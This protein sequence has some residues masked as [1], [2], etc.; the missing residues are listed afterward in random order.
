MIT[1]K[2]YYENG[3]TVI[4]NINSDLKGA[5]EYFLGKIFNI[6]SVKDNKQKCIKLAKIK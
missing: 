6:G 4:T 5:K 2:C 1:I 3:D